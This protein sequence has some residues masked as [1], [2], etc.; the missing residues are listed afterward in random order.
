M[1]ALDGVFIRG[2]ITNNN[3]LSEKITS[4]LIQITVKEHTKN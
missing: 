4:A 3:E 1:L 2:L